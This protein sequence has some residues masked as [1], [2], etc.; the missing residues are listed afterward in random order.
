MHAALEV[1]VAMN[2]AADRARRA[3]PRLESRDSL[4]HGPPDEPV[5]RETR[6]GTDAIARHPRHAPI[7]HEHDDPPHAAI[8]HEHVRAPAERGDRR[9]RWLRRLHDRDD[10]GFSAGLD[11]DVGPATDVK[12]RERGQ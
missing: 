8:A 2:G 6:A 11:E 3:R 4:S 10:L 7:A 5:D 12:R 1:R 9:L